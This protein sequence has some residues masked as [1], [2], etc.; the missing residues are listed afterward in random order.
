MEIVYPIYAHTFKVNRA[1]FDRAG[2][3]VEYIPTDTRLTKITLAIPFLPSFTTLTLTEYVAE[4]APNSL[5]FGQD[6]ILQ[7]GDALIGVSE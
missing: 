6:M 7:H 3:E 5:W 2:I 1:L 4:F